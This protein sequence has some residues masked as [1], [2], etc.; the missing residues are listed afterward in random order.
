MTSTIGLRV[1]AIT[2][3]R[4]GDSTKVSFK[5][6]TMKLLPTKFISSFIPNHTNIMQNNEM[7]RTWYFDEKFSRGS[8]NSSGYILYGTFGFESN[9]IDNKT[10]SKRYRR[11]ATDIEEIPLFY[12]FWS[13]PASD[14][15]LVC[16]Q[17]FQGRSCIGLVISRMQDLFE[18]AN[19]GF[20]LEF[21]KLIP[22]DGKGGIYSQAPVKRL[23]LIKRGA[24]S[25]LVDRLSSSDAAPAVVDLEVT[26]S[27]RR[28]SSLGT[29]LGITEAMAANE[30]G[31]IVYG[32]T[33]FEK[34]I[35]E[36]RIGNK[37]RRVSMLG[38]NGDAGVVDISEHIV[39]G[40]D[41]HPTIESLGKES[42]ILLKEF[43]S[44]LKSV[45]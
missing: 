18:V 9:L 10:K 22:A 31:V 41:G 21:K 11:R 29:F 14:F 39:K 19:P 30:A 17:S 35:A 12:E 37:T 28:K 34:V 40:S 45:K 3:H 23:R 7:E 44:L 33:P 32:G 16:F 13:P 43:Y 24:P 2:V 6:G 20:I 4:R 8:G 25:D 27:A 5:P 1:Y 26:I 15:S 38:E 42:R 36:V